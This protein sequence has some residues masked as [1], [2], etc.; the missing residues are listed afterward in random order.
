MSIWT[1]KHLKIEFNSTAI[2]W[3]NDNLHKNS[4]EIIE[5]SVVA[6]KHFKKSSLKYLSV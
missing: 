1:K 6:Y 4:N 3:Y 5:D 2:D